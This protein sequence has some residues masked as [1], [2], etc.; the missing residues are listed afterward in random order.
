MVDCN[1]IASVHI[2][3]HANAFRLQSLTQKKVGISAWLQRLKHSLIELEEDAIVGPSL[4]DDISLVGAISGSLI[5][6]GLRPES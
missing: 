3:P 5:H 4:Y 6:V 2:E 1:R